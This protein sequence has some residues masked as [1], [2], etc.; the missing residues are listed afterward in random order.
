MSASKISAESLASLARKNK[1][2]AA[3][4]AYEL[5]GAG[6]E[7]VDSMSQSDP[8]LAR[9]IENLTLKEDR[10]DETTSASDIVKFAEEFET[11]QSA[12]D[13]VGGMDA[14]VNLRAALQMSNET[15]A[16]FLQVKEL[17]KVLR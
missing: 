14:L 13:T 8:E 16:L 12:A 5:Y 10:I 17:G 4:I 11:I 9:I 15:I 6:S 1:V 7:I 2:T 3:L